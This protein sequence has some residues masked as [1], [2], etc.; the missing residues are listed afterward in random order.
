MDPQPDAGSRFP[1]FEPADWIC[2]RPRIEKR[3]DRRSLRRRASRR[4]LSDPGA[5]HDPDCGRGALRRRCFREQ[6]SPLTAV[7]ILPSQAGQWAGL[8]RGLRASCGLHF[9][10]SGMKSRSTGR[11]AV[12]RECFRTVHPLNSS[13]H[14]PTVTN[15]T[16][17]MAPRL[18]TLAPLERITTAFDL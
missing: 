14:P 3:P 4:S 5:N 12:A 1:A 15:K 17:C 7:A 8:Q 11:E 18:A 10:L 6:P 13:L 16:L 2:P 9:C